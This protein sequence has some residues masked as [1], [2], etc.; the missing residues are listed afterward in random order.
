M[1]AVILAA[2]RG[3]RMGD[4][5]DEV[6]K[7]LLRVHGKSLLEHK[8]ELLPE[9]IDEVLIVVGYLKEKIIKELGYECAGK[10]ITYVVM[11]ELTGTAS[12]FWLCKPLLT[13][14]CL[15]LMGD[16][17][18]GKED[19][20][21]AVTHGWYMGVQRST[22]P[23][24]GGNIT[25]TKQGYLEDVVEGGGMAGDYVN[26]GMY[27][28]GL[29]LFSY[30]M[31]QLPGGEYGLPQTIAKAA[32]NIPVSVVEVKTWIRITAPEDLLHAEKELVQ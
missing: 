24:V 7:P 2:G 25:V 9:I 10:K 15:I 31:V 30:D 8:I 3:K 29:E 19:L 27:V 1:Q 26:T 11:D 23:F 16:D 20:A 32:K 21:R 22:V 28:V 14:N 18:Y 12:A 17:L 6:P 13:G 4:L 5:T